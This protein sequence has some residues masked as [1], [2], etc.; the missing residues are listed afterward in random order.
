MDPNTALENALKA[1]QAILAAQDSDE[2]QKAEH[3]EILAEAFMALHGW[4]ENGGFLP[5][6]WRKHRR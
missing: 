6:E 4:M 3:A 5:S 2:P 1:A